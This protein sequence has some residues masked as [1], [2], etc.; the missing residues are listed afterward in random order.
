MTPRQHPGR[1]FPASAVERP[2]PARR[3]GL[4][5]VNRADVFDALSIAEQY[6]TV[7]ASCAADPVMRDALEQFPPAWQRRS[8][9]SRAAVPAPFPSRACGFER[10]QLDDRICCATRRGAVGEREE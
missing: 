9:L 7:F 6:E 1:C 2:P 3:L 5:Q 8:V 10:R 4:E